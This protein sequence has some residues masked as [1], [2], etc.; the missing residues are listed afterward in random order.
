MSERLRIRA[1]QTRREIFS[2]DA[3]PVHGDI[4]RFALQAVSRYRDLLRN[5]PK[6]N[7]L[8]SPVV[9]SGWVN[10]SL[11]LLRAFS[12]DGRPRWRRGLGHDDTRTW[13]YPDP[14]AN[15]ADG[16]DPDRRDRKSH[17]TSSP[18]GPLLHPR[19]ARKEDGPKRHR[20]SRIANRH[21]P[22]A[23]RS[24]RR[25]RSA[26]SAGSSEQAPQHSK[27][28]QR[29]WRA[30]LLSQTWTHQMV[31]L[32]AQ[33]SA[34]IPTPGQLGPAPVRLAWQSAPRWPGA[35]SQAPG[36]RMWPCSPLRERSSQ[37]RFW[38]WPFHP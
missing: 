6:W 26:Q 19:L 22:E 35:S 36:S 3:L 32:G 27:T 34:L 30:S 23:Q 29:S 18:L 11:L 4:S 7:L 24:P 16:S 8:T 15:R 33:R 13:P 2:D 28:L 14:R 38:R 12:V 1:S 17:P 5:G 20:L 9:N 25:K 37:L 10:V 31:R 21:A